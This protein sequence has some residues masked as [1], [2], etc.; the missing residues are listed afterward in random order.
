MLAGAEAVGQEVRT[1]AVSQ[2]GFRV[3]KGHFVLH[4]LRRLDE[5]LPFVH[6]SKE[7]FQVLA[8]GPLLSIFDGLVSDLILG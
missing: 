2:T 6:L 4:A 3:V 5:M 1:T 8:F 7:Q